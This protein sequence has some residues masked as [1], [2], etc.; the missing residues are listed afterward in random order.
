M[1]ALLLVFAFVL[2]LVQ[3]LELRLLLENGQTILEIDYS[4]FTVILKKDTKSRKKS[5]NRTKSALAMLRPIRF[6]SK[7]SSFTLRN[8]DLPINKATP[9]TAALK[10]GYL[11][12]AIIGALSLLSFFS[13]EISLYEN[14]I[15]TSEIG[16]YHQYPTL[17][18]TVE[19]RLF[20]IFYSLFLF[21]IEYI[22]RNEK[23]GRKQN[24]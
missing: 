15:N 24:E 6:L 2:I 22:K 9:S 7:K 3:K 16:D 14:S 17:D 8:I 19:C 10:T 5:K 12:S 23:N 20:H 13:S 4:V 18:F 21:L 11:H 1:A